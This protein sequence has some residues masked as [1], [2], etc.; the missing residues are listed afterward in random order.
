MEYL[1][2]FYCCCVETVYCFVVQNGP[3]SPVQ[4]K[5]HALVFQAL[6]TIGVHL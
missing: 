3:K 5:P 1:L 2:Y 4:S 6:T